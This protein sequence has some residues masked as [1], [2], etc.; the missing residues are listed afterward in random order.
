[1]T[2]RQ[3][4]EAKLSG[5]HRSLDPVEEIIVDMLVDLQSGLHREVQFR[6]ATNESTEHYLRLARYWAA[7]VG[8]NAGKIRKLC[9]TDYFSAHPEGVG[10]YRY[11]RP[12]ASSSPEE[13][14]R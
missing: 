3:E 10:F 14:G 2:A 9:L 1:M 4:V 6:A 7:V 8:I 12:Q 11:P 5:I 13:N